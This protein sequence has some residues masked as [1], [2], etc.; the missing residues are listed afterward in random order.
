MRRDREPLH[1]QWMMSVWVSSDSTNHPVWN[2]AGSDFLHRLDR[3][4]NIRQARSRTLAP[5]GEPA[6]MGRE[7]LTTI[8]VYQRVQRTWR[9]AARCRTQTGV[10]EPENP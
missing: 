3:L 7:D 6:H 1:L 5:E 8:K 9:K 10:G 4:P 2:S